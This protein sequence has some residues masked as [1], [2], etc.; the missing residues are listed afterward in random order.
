MA[1]S[2]QGIRPGSMWIHPTVMRT[3]VLPP[4]L[5]QAEESHRQF[6]LRVRET[7]V[8]GRRELLQSMLV[9]GELQRHLRHRMHVL[10][11][12]DRRQAKTELRDQAWL[13]L[14]NLPSQSGPWVFLGC[15]WS[16]MPAVVRILYP[17]ATLFVYDADEAHRR[18]AAQ[19]WQRG[20]DSVVAELRELPALPTKAIVVCGWTGAE[21]L[22]AASW[23]Q[24]RV[25]SS[26]LMRV[27]AGEQL[28]IA[29][30]PVTTTQWGYRPGAEVTAE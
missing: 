9:A 17:A 11:A 20:G 2:W 3:R 13:P 8:T 29:L 18:V 24:E 23:L 14:I 1:G 12:D 4:M 10:N 30:T 22:T 7:M 28:G 5:P 19:W 26:L 21:L 15:G 16:V 25:T 27:S 6:S